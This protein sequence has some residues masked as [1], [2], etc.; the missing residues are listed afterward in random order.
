MKLKTRGSSWMLTEEPKRS[1]FWRLPF[2]PLLR[3]HK[4]TT[5]LWCTDCKTSY[6]CLALLC[7]FIRNDFYQIKPSI[8]CLFL[9]W[10]DILIT[11][12]LC[13]RSSVQLSIHSKE[14]LHKTMSRCLNSPVRKLLGCSCLHSSSLFVF[15]GFFVQTLN[16]HLSVTP[17]HVFPY[18][19]QMVQSVTSS[20]QDCCPLLQMSIHRMCFCLLHP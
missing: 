5:L 4:K 20:K 12:N 9:T 8:T 13:D 6:S 14:T 15:V 19:G 2:F 16:V 3:T 10:N 11:S 17:T 1:L 7:N 18:S